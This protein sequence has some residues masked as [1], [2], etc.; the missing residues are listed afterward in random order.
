MAVTDYSI[1]GAAGAN[2]NRRTTEKEYQ[3]GITARGTNNT[4]W[5]YVQA[6]GTVAT[7]TCTVDSAFQLTDAAGDYTA[8]TAFADDEYGWVRLT[9]LDVA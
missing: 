1:A 2:F 9:A 5:V 4:A 3:L 7:G 6:N 8:D